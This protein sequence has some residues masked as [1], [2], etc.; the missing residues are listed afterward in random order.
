MIGDLILIV[1]KKFKQTFCIHHYKQHSAC[2][3]EYMWWKCE[4]CGRV[5][6]EPI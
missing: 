3:G 1:C 5:R 2:F 6:S 4:K